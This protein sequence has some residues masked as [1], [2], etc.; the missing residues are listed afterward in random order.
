MPYIATGLTAISMGLQIINHWPLETFMDT[1][2]LILFVVSIGVL[3]WAGLKKTF[4]AQLPVC[5]IVQVKQSSWNKEVFYLL[6]SDGKHRNLS[7]ITNTDSATQL[8]VLLR[9]VEPAITS[10]FKEHGV[11]TR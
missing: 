1:I 9:E 4:R 8:L 5:E 3:V 7:Q 10:N 2:F 11:S 6:L